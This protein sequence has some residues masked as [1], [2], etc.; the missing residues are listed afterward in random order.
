MP[1]PICTMM[2]NIFHFICRFRFIMKWTKIGK[3]WGRE[4]GRMGQR[5]GQNGAKNGAEFEPITI[6]IT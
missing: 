6:P 5:M 4:W 3:E 2:I 1:K